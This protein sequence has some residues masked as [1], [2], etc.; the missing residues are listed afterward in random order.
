MGEDPGQA[1]PPD[2]I[3]RQQDGPEETS[4]RCRPIHVQEFRQS[5]RERHKHNASFRKEGWCIVLEAA[6]NSAGRRIVSMSEAAF[7]MRHHANRS[8]LIGCKNCPKARYVTW[9]PS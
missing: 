6:C 4:I 5:T 3:L 7:A 9:L 2:R 8:M 1:R